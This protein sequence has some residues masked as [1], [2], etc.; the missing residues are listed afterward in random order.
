MHW[1]N[2]SLGEIIELKYGKPLP[3]EKRKSN[4]LHPAYGANGILDR[5][6]EYFSD[7]QSIIIGRKGSAGALT[8][9]EEKFWP[10]DVTYFL[11]FDEKKYDLKFL[12]YLLCRC[13]LTSLARGVKPGLNREDVYSISVNVPE[14]LEDQKQIVSLLDQADALRCKRRES[15]ALLDKYVQSVFMEM[16]GDPV[17]NP[18]KFI[19][20]ELQA[21]YKGNDATRCGP[22]GSALKKQDYSKEGIPVWTMENIKGMTFDPTSYL[23]IPESKYAELS[24]YKAQNGDIIISRAGTVGKMAIID[25]SDERSIIS[26]N[27][28]KLSLDE[29]KMLPLFFVSLMF[30][31]S[32]RLARLKTGKEGTFTHMNTGVLNSIKFPLPPIDLQKKYASAFVEAN[33]IKRMMQ[34]QLAQLENQLHALMHRSFSHAA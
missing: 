5:T 18:R 28:I 4:G 3:K 9:T 17:T 25:T 21:C 15:M 23:R 14:S 22:F 32:A 1:Q 2:K 12:Y 13:N 7:K 33:S 6:D 11:I 30:F 26:T 10:L 24:Q 19:I 34:T 16:F 8:L 20:T 29:K 31:C 27:L